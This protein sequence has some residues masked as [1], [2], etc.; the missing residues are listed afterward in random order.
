MRTPKLREN[1]NSALVEFR[2]KCFGSARRLRIALLLNVTMLAE[3]Q[4]LISLSQAIRL[5][6][7]LGCDRSAVAEK[8]PLFNHVCHLRWNHSLPVA[9][10]G[11]Q[12]AQHVRWMNSQILR[13]I[14]GNLVDVLIV[15]QISKQRAK[16]SCDFDL[17][18]ADDL[19]SRLIDHWINI[20]L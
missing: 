1:G 2:T 15:D 4:W 6:A 5:V 20:K 14:V 7:R 17:R 12:F 8:F 9:V 11:L 18:C 19:S 13:M 10:S 3:A 16:I